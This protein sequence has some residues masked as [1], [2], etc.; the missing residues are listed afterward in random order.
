MIHPRSPL[1]HS[2]LRGLTALLLAA[3]TSGALAA[4]ELRLWGQVRRDGQGVPGAQVVVAGRDTCR[5]DEGGNFSFPAMPRGPLTIRVAA[6]GLQTLR[7]R[8]WLRREAFLSLDM[9]RENQLAR[10]F[11]LD[12]L[13][14]VPA[15]LALPW[16]LDGDGDSDLWGT[17]PLDD[18]VQAFPGGLPAVDPW[19]GLWS[20]GLDADPARLWQPF[21]PDLPRAAT[22]LE[23]ALVPG[24]EGLPTHVQAEW[25]GGGESRLQGGLS[26]PLGLWQELS[27]QAG[28]RQGKPGQDGR[29]GQLAHVWHPAGTFRVEQRVALDQA[30][31]EDLDGQ[32]PRFFWPQ[33]SGRSWLD[34]RMQARQ[35]SWQAQAVASPAAGL[36][37][38]G[39]LW[40][41]R[42]DL[43]GGGREWDR[44]LHRVP[45]ADSI[46]SLAEAWFPTRRAE[47]RHAAGL[48]LALEQAH[49]RG[50]LQGSLQLETQRRSQEA[51]LGSTPWTP[52]GLDPWLSL[53]EQHVRVEARLVDQWRLNRLLILLAGLD[54]RYA[55]HELHRRP[56]GWFQLSSVPEVGFN[57]DLLALEPRL[58][59][60]AALT[61]NRTLQL[62][63]QR[64]H[65]LTT[66][67]G[68][69][70]LGASVE[71]LGDTPLWV[72]YGS[73]EE[74]ENRLP[75]PLL[76]EVSLRGSARGDLLQG[77]GGL[78]L[79]RWQGFP[80]AGWVNEGETPDPAVLTRALDP[81]Q[82]G[83]EAGLRLARGAWSVELDGSWSWTRLQGRLWR[84]LPDSGLVG[85]RDQTLR[86]LPGEPGWRARLAAAT[87]WEG[88]H[89][90]RWEPRVEIIGLGPRDPGN[91]A[92]WTRE[93]PAS[94]RLD[95]EL[96]LR[97]GGASPWSLALWG[98]N[99]G[100][101]P[102]SSLAWVE[103][104]P[105]ERVALRHEAEGA[106]RTVGLRLRWEPRP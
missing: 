75:S 54:L 33:A 1:L 91:Q 90:L 22:G 40:W 64:R 27:L 30:D 15:A 71:R 3:W 6:P 83:L 79:R 50:T 12:S 82:A 63:W 11:P 80:L 105:L 36:E 95:A 106:A 44:V 4:D 60:T 74:W 13:A 5:C 18:P 69:W 97:P 19:G 46:A 58:A 25:R 76:D 88:W 53:E 62:A 42:R 41:R 77:R 43:D 68:M 84:P 101:D 102:H 61:P 94:L 99:L 45:A 55:F 103:W 38:A 47:S 78:W 31:W 26:R 2:R 86:R 57:R 98:R 73:E 67:T 51:S 14:T 23:G 52:G 70:D 32:A 66:T 104:R 28:L 59:L 35:A 16:D 87:R 92:G 85:M 39:R 7:H 72:A 89:G 29:S 65:A 100:A 8:L 56:V 96:V 20:G 81:L 17:R 9:S 24:P 49:A 93:T 37:L 21:Q 34:T 10:H 48:G